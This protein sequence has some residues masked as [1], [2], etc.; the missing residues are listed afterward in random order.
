[1]HCLHITPLMTNNTSDCNCGG[2]YLQK[3][4]VMIF[5]MG[6][7]DSFNQ[8]RGH[9]L[10]QEPLPDIS[11]VYSMVL[12]DENQREI[13]SS[14]TEQPSQLTFA[15]NNNTKGARRGHLQCLHCGV[16]GHTQDKCFKL[17]DFPPCYEK[18]KGSS[19]MFALWCPWSHQGQVL[20]TP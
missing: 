17:H 6:L 10:L 18:Q 15:V 8:V 5:L 20:Q 4:H 13:G 11:R 12:Q 2:A 16:F 9:I 1:M 14:T 3:E 7:N 19:S